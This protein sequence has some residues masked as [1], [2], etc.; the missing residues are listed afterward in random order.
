[1]SS[2]QF[3][4]IKHILVNASIKKWNANS[5]KQLRT[6][7]WIVNMYE[8]IRNLIAVTVWNENGCK[9]IV[10]KYRNDTYKNK[11]FNH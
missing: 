8:T 2:S 10:A 9:I 4:Q 5:H 1:M 7:L 3:N 6:V 11:L